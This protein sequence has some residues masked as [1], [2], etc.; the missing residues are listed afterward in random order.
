MEIKGTWKE[1]VVFINESTFTGVETRKGGGERGGRGLDKALSS[2]K[3]RRRGHAQEC[4]LRRNLKIGLH[5]FP[6]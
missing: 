2:N 5:G 6:F 1:F 4:V 3:S